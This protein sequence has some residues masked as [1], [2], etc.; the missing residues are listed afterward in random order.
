MNLKHQNHTRAFILL[1]LICAFVF[2]FINLNGDAPAGDISRSGVFYVD[3]GTYA[4]NA[5]NKALFGEWFLK[6]DYNPISNIPIFSLCQYLFLKLFGVSLQTIRFG[7]IVYSLISLL[8]MWIILKPYDFR[9]AWLAMIFG[10]SNYFFIIYNRLAL[11]ENLLILFLCLITA[12]LF[13]YHRKNK[14]I[15]LILASVI[16]FAGYFVKATIIFYT[17]LFFVAIFFS[18]NSLKTKMKHASIFILISFALAFVS[19][20]V[21]I[22]PHQPDWAYFQNLNISAKFTF[23]PVHIMHNYGRYIFNLKLFQFMPVT[24]TLFLFSIGTIIYHLF[25]GRR[26]P[27]IELFFGTWALCG[28]IFLGFFA[29]S[30]PRFSLI[31]M[32]AIFSLVSLFLTRLFRGEFN[33]TGRSTNKVLIFITLIVCFQIWFGFFRIFR[34][35]HLYP[36]CFFPLFAL[37]ALYLLRRIGKNPRSTIHAFLF[38]SAILVLNLFQT[39]HYHVTIQ[40]SYYHAM[41]SMK[42]FIQKQPEKQRVIAGDI[43]PLVA[44]ELNVKAV[45][46]LFRKEM[47]RIRFLQQR[48]RFLML[49]DKNE[50]DRL[51]QKLQDYLADVELIKSYTIFDNYV[52][53]DD[54]YFYKI[55]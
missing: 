29:Y 9:A 7:G 22:I 1:I 12:V 5:V 55:N 25:Q 43:A 20:A 36:S 54:T 46:I 24:Y 44:T 15:W 21:W 40:H 47:E 17:P 10:A 37:P 23:S 19:Y 41:Q 45:N 31:L 3:E 6:N 16:F 27:F 2:R 33:L 4:H 32:P 51:R 14:I 49:Q 28:F 11:L 34:D 42:D 53:N 50:L 35:G 18:A 8:L 26:V 38:L 39:T 30:P 13:L 48:P 52:T